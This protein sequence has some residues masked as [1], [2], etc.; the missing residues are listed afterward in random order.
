MMKDGKKVMIDT[1]ILL[2]ANMVNFPLHLNAQQHLQKLNLE[3]EELWVSVQIVREYM[4]SKSRITYLDGCYDPAE[5]V[6]DVKE[7][8]NNFL[9]AINNLG[10]QKEHLRLF[11]K[12]QVKGKQVHDCNIVATMIAN[13]IGSLFTNNIQDFKRYEPEGINIIPLVS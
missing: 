13:D 1:N 2:Y 11:E 8:E 12:Y 4:A 7:F 6:L 9:I 5:I 10:T 3:L